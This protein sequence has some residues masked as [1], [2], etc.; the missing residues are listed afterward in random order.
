V[1]IKQFSKKLEES[2]K[3]KSQQSREAELK[4]KSN[5]PKL[6]QNKR[7]R[8][9]DS[10]RSQ[11]PI[12]ESFAQSPTKTISYSYSVEPSPPMTLE[13]HEKRERKEHLE[14]LKL[15]KQYYDISFH[16]FH[17]YYETPYFKKPY[18]I[19]CFEQFNEDT[20]NIDYLEQDYS[21][22]YITP[23]LSI[24][25][26]GR[27]DCWEDLPPE[28]WMEKCM[29]N[30]E[31]VDSEYDGT[32]PMYD[33]AN[34]KFLW[35]Y[36]TVLSYDPAKL[37]YRVKFL[38][39]EK[40]V[41]RLSLMFRWEDQNEF[42]YRKFLCEKRRARVDQF[43]L[44]TRYVDNVPTELVAPLNFDWQKKIESKVRFATKHLIEK[45]NA[46]F[47][48]GSQSFQREITV[49]KQD[50]L[51]QMKKCRILLEMQEP[52]NKQKF[53]ERSLEIRQFYKVIPTQSKGIVNHSAEFN[54]HFDFINKKSFFEDRKFIQDLLVSF[55]QLAEDMKGIDLIL[56]NIDDTLE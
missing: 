28:V 16:P 32:S 56:S 29:K 19:S 15:I 50:F 31:D 30:H 33:Y 3:Q 42:D 52:Q 6:N 4:R 47:D 55:L 35:N 8:S 20:T 49:V 38:H 37:K 36:V 53:K 18:S 17:K 2:L 46:I 11:S 26:L 54:K 10:H 39:T 40:D 5:F 21:N 9:L 23:L 7:N 14:V 51:R 24:K 12:K 1:N 13:I 45:Y 25:N 43:N 44:F 48:E 41:S 27:Y 34:D 22:C